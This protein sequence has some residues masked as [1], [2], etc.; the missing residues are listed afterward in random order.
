LN[1]QSRVTSFFEEMVMEGG[2]TVA[3]CDYCGR[4]HFESHDLSQYG[5][6]EL[7]RYREL[8]ERKPNDYVE[9]LNDDSIGIGKIAD[10]LLVIGC[11][12][13]GMAKWEAWF[14]DNSE[15]ISR[16]FNERSNYLKEQVEKKM[17]E[18]GK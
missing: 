1:N 6:G 13:E 17:K 11:S 15:K 3:I 12:C 4:C 18:L 10:Q 7:E 8:A 16:Y 14:W 2:T 9:H 5:D